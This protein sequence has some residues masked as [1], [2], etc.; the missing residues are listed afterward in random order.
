M[1]CAGV[2]A[3]ALLF[4]V[5]IYLVAPLKLL[6]HSVPRNRLGFKQCPVRLTDCPGALILALILHED[7]LFFEHR[8]INLREVWNRI[9]AYFKHGGR[10]RGG[11]SI[12]QQLV[13]GL[14][15][16]PQGRWLR[17]LREL[18][19]TIKLE[20]SYSKDQILELYLNHSRWGERV[21]GIEAASRLYFGI[22]PKALNLIEYVLLAGLLPHPVTSQYHLLHEGA[23][24]RYDFAQA[25][26][27]F[28]E[29]FRFVVRAFGPEALSR[30]E[31]LRFAEVKQALRRYARSNW[32]P[33]NP[34]LETACAFHALRACDLLRQRLRS[35]EPR[36]ARTCR[37]L[38]LRLTPEAALI[39]RKISGWG[40]DAIAALA[41]QRVDWDDLRQLAGR[42]GV[43]LGAEE[44]ALLGE[45]L[46]PELDSAELERERQLCVAAALKMAAAL[47]DILAALKAA[48]IPVLVL[49]GPA[50]ALAYYGGLGKRAFR[51]IDLWISSSDLD[52][53]L[54]KLAHLGIT[55]DSSLSA[56][57]LRTCLTFEG[58]LKLTWH[59][60]D[61]QIDLHTALLPSH[62]PAFLNF[63]CVYSRSIELALPEGGAS[64]RALSHED[65]L[66]FMA[67]H[68]LKHCWSRAVWIEDVAQLLRSSRI[69]AE[70]LRTRARECGLTRAL[71]VSLV[72]AHQIGGAE[73]PGSLAQ[74]VL[75][76]FPANK[77]ALIYFYDL[78]KARS[79]LLAAARN[80]RYQ[81]AALEHPRLQ[82]RLILGRVCAPTAADILGHAI[83]TRW[84]AYLIRAPRIVSAALE[85]LGELCAKSPPPPELK[86]IQPQ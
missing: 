32:Q 77:L 24:D 46:V 1:A 18:I 84:Y 33:L 43:R 67:L 19:Y 15:L 42:H 2:V 40:G 83:Q 5:L 31:Q 17:K 68:G 37:N 51:D 11:S 39:V 76:D 9:K 53:A 56:T 48:D 69:D 66:L 78:F 64:F 47:R 80:L 12:S 58:A 75:D 62:Y 74:E 49:K 35:L 28:H 34:D 16:N 22:Q 85:L 7:D 36:S 71:W 59:S 73:L 20:R 14:F 72:L 25:L 21:F 29:I 13:R 4:P 60:R 52:L 41:S 10:L 3:I 26:N 81:S 6:Q 65:A 23:K 70:A 63:Q 57:G 79:G 30:L 8:G 55:P 86:R 38:S 27:K 44:V 61:L 45:G 82:L 50:Y 54:A